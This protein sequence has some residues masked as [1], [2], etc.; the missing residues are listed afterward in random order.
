[1]AWALLLLLAGAALSAVGPYLLGRV[2][3]GPLTTGDQRELWLLAALYAGVML[4]LF[5]IQFGQTVLLQWAG[6]RALADLRV[7]LFGHMLGQGQGFFDRRSVGSLV[8]NITADIDALNA[9]L[10]SSVVTIVSESATLIV[11][12]GVIEQGR[13]V[14]TGDHATLL[15]CGGHYARLHRHQHIGEPPSS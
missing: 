3:D 13:V 8:A 14:E 5:V 4:L 7:R 2:I 9:L 6:Q 1:M 11:I 15:A 10:S 12:I